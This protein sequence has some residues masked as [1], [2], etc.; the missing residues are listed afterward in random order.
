[1]RLLIFPLL[2]WEIFPCNYLIRGYEWERNYE[3][4]FQYSN[5]LYC[6]PIILSSFYIQY[7]Q[8]VILSSHFKGALVIFSLSHIVIGCIV[9]EWYCHWWY[10]NWWYWHCII[11][12]LCY[13]FIT[14]CLQVLCYR[15]SFSWCYIFIVFYRHH[16]LL[17][18]HF[19]VIMFY[20]HSALLS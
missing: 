10:C 2:W 5:V 15:I 13:I 6:Y 17:S 8:C 19:I 20:C 9:I 7:F 3:E 18:S 12:S 4:I 16:I 1:M 11:L 14:Y